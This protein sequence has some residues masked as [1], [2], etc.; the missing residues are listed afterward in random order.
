MT[1]QEMVQQVLDGEELPAVIEDAIS[2]ARKG[3]KTG[4]FELKRTA[5]TGP[6][7]LALSGNR[8]L[9]AAVAQRL[10]MKF[11]PKPGEKQPGWYGEAAENKPKNRIKC[12]FCD[13]STPAW[14][15]AKGG[16]SK[17][18]YPRLADH[19]EAYHPHDHKRIMRWMEA[20]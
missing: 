1:I 19:V 5:K 9:R 6:K 12:R 18:G 14:T 3:I 20:E 17:S 4:E 11:R 2:R 13:W 10:G 8:G 7:R 15:R 16:K